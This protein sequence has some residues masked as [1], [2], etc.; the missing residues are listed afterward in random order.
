MLKQSAMATGASVLGI[1]A[2]ATA[3]VGVGLPLGAAAVILGMTALREIDRAGG[4][5]GGEKRARLGVNL[6]R[7]GAGGAAV[8]LAA[9]LLG[10]AGFGGLGPR[11]ALAADG[12]TTRPQG[13][14][15][16]QMKMDNGSNLTQVGKA[17]VLW[18]DQFY[19]QTEDFPRT[20][21]Q[22]DPGTL[23]YKIASNS[24]VDRLGALVNMGSD[25]LD[26][27]RLVN[28]IGTEATAK[29]NAPTIVLKPENVSYALLDATNVEWKNKVNAAAPLA[30]DKQVGKGS[31]WN[32]KFWEGSVMWGDTHITY[33]SGENEKSWPSTT[34]NGTTNVHDDLFKGNKG[35][36]STDAVM[37]NP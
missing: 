30:C 17:L 6:G 3:A 23:G 15:L 24:V 29:G 27:K 19:Q 26:P 7:I 25:K 18:S 2:L 21:L 12:A 22:P 13:R 34:I 1:A 16:A 35:P 14:A 10:V 8:V 4:Q 31:Y 37:E 28:P 9:V 20:G 33:E 11:H 5:M 36:K 32:N